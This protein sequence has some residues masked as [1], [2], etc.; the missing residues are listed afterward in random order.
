MGAT[1]RSVSQI[2]PLRGMRGK[3]QRTHPGAL[4]REVR[5]HG[6]YADA[7]VRWGREGGGFVCADH[8]VCSTPGSRPI[9][10]KN[11]GI[12]RQQ[13]TTAAARPKI[14]NGKK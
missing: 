2:T 5:K 10:R 4:L 8:A 3:R 6:V 13:K 1:E 9:S 14:T 11:L 12:G 7:H